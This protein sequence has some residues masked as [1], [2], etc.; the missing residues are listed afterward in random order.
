ML[1][2]APY[3]VSL[4]SALK[5]RWPGESSTLFV[6]ARMTQN[7]DQS[8]GFRCLPRGMGAFYELWS[9][10][11]KTR[12]DMV[13]VAGWQHPVVIAAI[14]LTKIYGGTIVSLS[15]TWQSN[16]KGI[17]YLLRKFVMSLIDQFAPAG[18]RQRDF[19]IRLGISKSKITVINLTV[20]VA[21]M[22]AFGEEMT[23]QRR[24]EF[25]SGHGLESDDVIV[26]WVGRFAPEKGLDTLL[27]AFDQL[28][29]IRGG[30]KLLL[31]GEGDLSIDASEHIKPIGWKSGD[32][33]YSA[34]ASTDIFVGTSLMESW[35]LV[36]NEA[37]AFGL[38]VVVADC[39]GCLDDLVEHNVTGL[40]A[41][42]GSADSFTDCL[43]KLI[44]D[45]QLREDLGE[46]G[47]AKISG[48]TSQ[49]MADRLVAAY[50]TVK[51]RN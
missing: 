17:K 10:F 27:T 35:G 41:K 12:P 36:V 47:K 42:T 18:S 26:I 14:I 49:M 46:N 32:D 44:D 25:R 4:S 3:M 2:P 37:M 6:S 16:S 38:P 22:K 11:H 50:S 21:G 13:L 48:W 43:V 9:V 33:L 28:L 51:E 23:T 24:D 19:L 29:A 8:D 30:V 15:D 5:E 40:V 7:W 31:V 45:Q 20:N 34:Y 39:Y 1:E